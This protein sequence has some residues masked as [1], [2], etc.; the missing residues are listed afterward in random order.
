MAFQIDMSPLE[1]SSRTVGQSLVDIGQNITGA[2]D[3]SRQQQE[4]G[5]IETFMRQAMSGDQAALQE[6]MVKSPQAARMVAEHIQGQ[7]TVQQGEQDRFAGEMANNTADFIEQMHTAPEDQQEL[8]FNAAIDDPRFDIDEEDRGLFMDT[9]ARKAII[10]KVK[11][12][13]YADN[14][15]G[16]D[17]A[18]KFQQG[19]GD[20]S[21]YVFNPDAGTFSINPE[22]KAKLDRVKAEPNLD[23]KD[24]QSLNKDFTTL[25]KDTKLIRNTAKD[26][27]KLSKINSGPASIAMVFKFM[28]ALDPTSVVR[29]GEF[30]TAENSSGIPEKVRNTYNKIMQGERLGPQQMAE[31]VL[32][33]KEL[34]N[35]AIDSSTTEITGFLD[36]FEDTIPK[37]FRNSLLKRIPM[38]FDV[39]TAPQEVSQSQYD[40]MPDGTKYTIDGVDYVKGQ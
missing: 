4:Q 22:L 1:R 20:M 8:M 14:F 6:L 37:G 9:N 19:T 13:E 10:G 38:R 27:E 17:E 3:Q 30:A 2:I 24:R 39:A 21:G 23:F 7:Q 35:S 18:T 32:T 26:L 11:G 29:E 12:K 16:G 36:T 40:S 28:K 34:A 25:T 33:A 15:F 5:N 31:F